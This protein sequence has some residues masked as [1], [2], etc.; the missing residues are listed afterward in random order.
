MIDID[1]FKKYNDNYGHIAGDIVLKAVARIFLK[2]TGPK[3]I[4][5]RYGGEEFAIVLP[6][7]T[8]K[9]AAELAEK[10]RKKVEERIF[11]LRR[12]KTSVTISVGVASAVNQTKDVNHLIAEAD[13]ALYEAKKA[14]R[15]KVCIS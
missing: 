5:A 15:N 11:Y 10:L 7:T 3:A 4:V 13:K 1:Y 14:G 12:E 6:Q 2:M 9:E 8:E